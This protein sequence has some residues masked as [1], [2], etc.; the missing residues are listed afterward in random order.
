MSAIEDLTAAVSALADDVA[1]EIAELASVVSAPAGND[2][3]IQASV[4]KLKE[5]SASL[6]ASVVPA[7][8]VV[9]PPAAPAV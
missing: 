7:P 8:V 3:A 2:T 5:L 1:T 9:E 6:K 4:A